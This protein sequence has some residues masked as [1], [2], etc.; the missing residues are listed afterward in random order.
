[1]LVSMKAILEDAN[2]NYYGVMAMN[3]INIE[4]ARAG[5]MAAE[6]EH[7]PIIIQFGPGQMK[8]HAHMEKCFRWWRNWQ[9]GCMY[10]LP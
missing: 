3:S 7:S 9:K 4:M 1:M 10:P 5:I 2:T 6:E 8:N